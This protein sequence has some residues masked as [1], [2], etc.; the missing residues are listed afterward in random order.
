M[1]T[2]TLAASSMSLIFPRRS[3]TWA[4]AACFLLLAVHGPI[5]AAEINGQLFDHQP[6]HAWLENYDPTLVSSRL[7]SEF[8]YESYANDSDNYKI[9]TT[10]RWGIPIRDGLALGLQVMVPMKWNESAAADA[11]GLGDLEI[12]TGIVGRIS[13]TLR[14][15]VGLNAAFDTAS[16][17]ALGDNAF[18]L[19]PMTAIRWDVSDCINLGLNIEYNFTPIDEGANDVSALE[20]KFPMAYKLSESWAAA[21]TYKPKWNLLTDSDPHRLELGVIRQWGSDTQYAWSLG[22]EV[23]LT[24]ESFKFKWI[25]GFAWYF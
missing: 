10:L 3:L 17:P 1:I 12:R 7:L 19:R 20:L 22:A 2:R 6:V 11:S 21:V 4:D 25:T 18:V 16:D 24:S 14:Y 8:S 23:P 9:E 13:P 5:D 15:G